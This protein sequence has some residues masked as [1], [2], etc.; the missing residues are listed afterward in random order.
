MDVQLSGQTA[1]RIGFHTAET[2][3]FILSVACPALN[4]TNVQST[5]SALLTAAKN[6]RQMIAHR[7]A[8]ADRPVI[9]YCHVSWDTAMLPGD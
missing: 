3:Q 9:I 7:V 1:Q 6:G 5:D 8:G 4:C 2:H